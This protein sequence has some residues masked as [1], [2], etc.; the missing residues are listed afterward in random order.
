MHVTV[1]D[2][3]H[4][5]KRIMEEVRKMEGAYVKVGVLSD[6]GTYDEGGKANLV[7]IATWN[8]YGTSKG[9]PARP[10]MGQTF[11]K[12]QQQ[13]HEA[14]G[15]EYGLILDGKANANGA[16]KTVGVWYKGE[17]QKTFTEGEFEPNAPST[18][19]KK[20][21]SQ[22]LIDTGRLRSSINFEVVGA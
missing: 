1:E 10:F 12:N 3:D 22:P 4:G 14:L 8:E 20:G 15:N 13:T 11:D 16:L 21:S 18:I 2:I 19:A 17:I 7:D 9:I 5:L 6:A